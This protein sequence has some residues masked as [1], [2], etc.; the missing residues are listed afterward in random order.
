MPAP[1][2]SAHRLPYSVAP[3]RYRLRLA[4]DLEAFRFDGEVAIELEVVEA[5]STITLNAADLEL[6][7]ATL[8]PRWDGSEEA[9]ALE[10]ALD[11]ESERATFT[12]PSEI[13]LGPY[14][15]TITYTGVINDK[16]HGFYR[17]IYTDVNGTE[18]VLAVTQ[19]ETADARRALPCFD[20]PDRKARFAVTL[21]LPPEVSAVANGSDVSSED[22]GEGRRRVTYSD[23]PPMAT[24][25]L[26]FVI[27]H[28]EYSDTVI[29]EGTPVR[30][31]TVAGKSHLHQAAL[32]ASAHALGFF[33][34]YFALSYLGDKLDLVAVPDFA[35]GAMENVGC[36]TFRESILLADPENT[37]RPELERLAE[38]TEHELAHMWF[39]DL[40]TMRWWNGLWLNESFATFMALLCIDDYH[41]EWNSF[42]TAARGRVAALEIDALHSTRAVEFPAE[43]PADAE[44]MVDTLTYEK[45]S[46]VLWMVQAFVGAETFRAAIRHYLAKHEFG[47]TETTDLWDA[48]GDEA[49]DVPMR[50]LMDSWIFQGGVPLVTAAAGTD[51][52][53]IVTISQE[54]F[55]YLP[56]PPADA[57][58]AVGSDWLIP[59]IAAHG[60][61]LG[62]TTRLLLN[63]P[64]A[65]EVSGPVLLNSGGSGYYRV[66]YDE[67]LFTALLDE[68]ATLAPLERFDLV[69]DTNALVVARRQPVSRLISLIDRL[70]IEQDPNVLAAVIGAIQNLNLVATA[71]DRALLSSYVKA[72]IG[73]ILDAVGPERR[74]GEALD[75]ALVRAASSAILG[76]IGADPTVIERAKAVVHADLGGRS[77]LDPDLA[78]AYLAVFAAHADRSDLDALLARLAQ[79][80]DPKDEARVRSSLAALTDISLAEVV[81]DRC[82]T[83][84]RA[85]DSPYLLASMLRSRALS[86]ATYGFIS[87]RFD[88]IHARIA[89]YGIRRLVEGVSGLAALDADDEAIDVAS[90][91]AFFEPRVSGAEARHLA[92]ALE[93][94]E[95]AVGFGRVVRS[96]LATALAP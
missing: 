95:A 3:R 89:D 9:V 60:K 63:E 65:L 53:G 71:A 2:S 64:T 36:V 80:R 78:A 19:F 39:G 37:S 43:T 46:S 20:E 40:V 83:E 88:A 86:R 14:T 29:Q 44:A 48:I 38:V 26:A 6:S 8:S 82:L 85:Q 87:E 76:T 42:V 68:L 52:D 25:L 73:P 30:V 91:R 31:V 55:T 12:A 81:Y 92:Q 93:R 18:R 28:L 79:P 4:P 35:F 34:E 51:H 16:M 61:G 27:G 50:R 84:I 47:N 49:P 10:I 54:P 15:L 41:P 62:E 32:D 21:D 77:R 22:L 11:T 45:G 23:T 7:A 57:T 17:S 59:V 24:Y 72:R 75:D 66:A 70:G 90:V 1:E 69:S 33:Q 58:S 67:P 13:D 56:A 94:L 74:S 96:D 5:T